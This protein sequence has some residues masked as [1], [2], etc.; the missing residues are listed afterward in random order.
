MYFQVERKRHVGN[1]I[2]NIVFV[3]CDHTRSPSF[4]PSMMKTHFTRIL[5]NAYGI[6]TKLL[7]KNDIIS[8]HFNYFYYTEICDK[9]IK[10]LAMFIYIYLN[11][12]EC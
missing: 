1:D 9:L 2:V 7:H 11:V 4:R 8:V 5:A 3:D 12:D 6:P 10:H